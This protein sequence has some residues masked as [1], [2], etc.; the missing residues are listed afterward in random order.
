MISSADASAAYR[1]DSPAGPEPGAVD[2][3]EVLDRE[4]DRLVP[5]E[6]FSIL[7]E[8]A[9]DPMNGLEEIGPGVYRSRKD[10]TVPER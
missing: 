4:A 6:R 10:S 1:T 7:A 8:L 3:P 9:K 5:S 2:E